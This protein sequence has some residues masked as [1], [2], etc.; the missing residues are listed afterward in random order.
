MTGRE[1]IGAGGF[2]HVAMLYASPDE[3]AAGMMDVVR[4]GLSGGALVFVAATGPLALIPLPVPAIQPGQRDAH[5]R[6]WLVRLPLGL[7]LGWGL[8]LLL[9][10]LGAH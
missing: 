10:L 3:F 1:L 9:A 4:T 7:P 8:I 6:A 5:L 2:Q